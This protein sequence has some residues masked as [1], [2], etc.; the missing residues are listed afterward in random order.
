MDH[1]NSFGA[2]RV[3]AAPSLYQRARQRKPIQ[4]CTFEL[5]WAIQLAYRAILTRHLSRLHSRSRT[6]AVRRAPPAVTRAAGGTSGA[7]VPAGGDSE[8]W[9]S[10]DIYPSPAWGWSKPAPK[11]SLVKFGMDGTAS[12]AILN[13]VQLVHWVPFLF[14]I[15]LSNYILTNAATII[16]TTGITS[17][18]V[19]TCRLTCR[20]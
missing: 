16:K 6:A 8:D 17:T 4:Q 9:R 18:Q 15:P 13:L 5:H 7:A 12:P 1:I 11:A 19:C 3:H 14:A 20:D 2:V 10:C